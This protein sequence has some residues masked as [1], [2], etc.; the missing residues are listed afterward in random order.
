NGILSGSALTMLQCVKN[1]HIQ[2]DIELGEA[3]RMCSVYPAKIMGLPY[4]SGRL[5]I[6]ERADFICLDEKL[7]RL[8]IE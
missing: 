5:E 6:N 8:R 2:C 4:I 1:F 3:I 7:N